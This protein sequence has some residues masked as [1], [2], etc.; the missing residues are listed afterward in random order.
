[1]NTSVNEHIW[2][3][4][5]KC[6]TGECSE[7]ETRELD[8]WIS[9]NDD[10]RTLFNDA[11]TILQNTK[12]AL[13]VSSLR[14][15]DA[16]SSITDKIQKNEKLA[17]EKAAK[18]KRLS[19]ILRV[20]ASVALLISLSVAYFNW[21]SGSADLT[22]VT[23][24]GNEIREIILPDGSDVV[25]NGGSTLSYHKNMDEDDRMI[26]LSGEAFFKVRPDKE[27]PF[28]VNTGTI[29]VKVLGTTFNV[30]AYN[31]KNEASV[32]VESGT[33]QVSSGISTVTLTKGETALY[34]KNGS[35]LKKAKNSD[36][37]FK[38]WKT[39]QIRFMNTPLK[40]ALSTLEDIYRINIDVKDSNFIKN[41]R[42]NAD[43]D[44]Q[45]ADF[46]LN[47]ICETYHLSY[48]KKGSDYL[49]T[50]KK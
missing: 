30:K 16:F 27:H 46:I 19:I 7:E 37:N 33:V 42:I 1:M 24:A 40:D 41:K 3:L 10:N 43:F 2:A 23:T 50:G 32:V 13:T 18:A 26:T 45:T 17:V 6:Q 29:K 47:T 8:S 21:R 44:K 25:I 31:D 28:V 34:S 48:T 49:I 9:M 20:A 38:A 35:T 4:I 22:T 36:I 11:V 5:A 14:K 15:K 12:N 39:K